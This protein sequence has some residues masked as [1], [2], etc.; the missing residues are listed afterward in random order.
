MNYGE[1]I[2]HAY[3]F[4]KEW[5]KSSALFQLTTQ[6]AGGFAMC[7]MVWYGGQLVLDHELTIGQLTSF[8]FYT[9]TIG[10]E[11]GTMAGLYGGAWWLCVLAS[12]VVWRGRPYVPVTSR[13]Q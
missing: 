5:A 8:L 12:T 9:V 10:Q 2:D 3:N 4:R 7:T 6:F 13:V 1:V 11:M